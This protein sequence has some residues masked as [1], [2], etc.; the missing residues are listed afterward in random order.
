MTTDYIVAMSQ[1][2]NNNT[3]AVLIGSPEQF[4]MLARRA[5][6][7]TNCCSIAACSGLLAVVRASNMDKPPPARAKG[8]REVLQ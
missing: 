6:H 2:E 5:S 1:R 7:K 4:I 8:E 3:V